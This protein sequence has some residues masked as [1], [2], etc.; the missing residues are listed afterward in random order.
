ME[1]EKYVEMWLS[2]QIP[3]RDWIKILKER[4]DV[5]KMYYDLIGGTDAQD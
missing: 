5:R 1:A 2:E 4:D 3:I